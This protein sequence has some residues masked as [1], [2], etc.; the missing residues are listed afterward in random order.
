MKILDYDEVN[1]LRVLHLT[2]L[3]LDFSLTPEHAAHIRQT[4]PRPFPCFTVNAVED[5]MVLGQVGVF[6]LPMISTEGREDVGGVW[7]VST[8]PN[9]AGRGIASALLEEAHIRMRDAGLRFSTLGTDRSRVSYRLYQRHGYVDMNVWATALT[10]WETAHQPTHLRA[11]S[12]G[13]EGYDFVEKIF[14]DLASDYLGFAWRYTPFARLRDKVNLEE[15][16]ALWENNAVVGYVFAHQEKSMLLINVQ[17]LRPDINATEAIAAIAAELKAPY[18]QV[19]VSRPSDIDSLR[20]A[21][22]QVAHPDWGAFMVKPLL[23]DLTAEDAC[24]FFGIGMDCF[25]ISWLDTT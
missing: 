5:E 13:S 8:H 6:R 17:L 20:R 19:S 1:P 18:V 2:M 12:L 14:A 15:I 21:G 22:W 16:W 9:Y 11:Q 4:D 10:N 23:P 7:A 3:A 24:G 25:L